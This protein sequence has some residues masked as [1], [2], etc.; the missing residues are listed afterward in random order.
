MSTKEVKLWACTGLTLTLNCPNHY[1]SYVQFGL[2][3]LL[4]MTHL[5]RYTLQ[6]LLAQW[7]I[8]FFGDYSLKVGGIYFPCLEYHQVISYYICTDLTLSD[9]FRSVPLGTSRN[10]LDSEPVEPTGSTGSDQNPVGKIPTV[11]PI[12]WSKIS[13]RNPTSFN[14]FWSEPAGHS[15][16]LATVI[17]H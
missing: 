11:W 15:K 2:Q 12:L 4:M 7:F 5:C 8:I 14:R 10:W 9:Q 3:I 13:N 16:D 6:I 1:L 17:R